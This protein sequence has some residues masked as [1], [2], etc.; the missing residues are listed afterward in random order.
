M[1]KEHDVL[2]QAV[3]QAGQEVLK[4]SRE[5]FQIY[6]KAD[7]SPVTSADLAANDILHHALTTAFPDDAWLSEESPDTPG[8]LSQP[9]VW[10][11]DPIDGT[12]YFIKGLPQYSI[13]VALADHAQP[14]LGVIY[15]PATDELFSAIHGHGARLN[16][17]PIPATDRSSGRLSLLVN[18]TRLGSNELQ[19]FTGNAHLHPMGS[20]AY[21]LALVAAG[22]ADG[23]V[24]FDPLHE[25]D[26][27][28]G[29]LLVNEAGGTTTDSHGN[30][31]VYNQ[32]NPLVRGI[33]AARHG[34][35]QP[36]ETLIAQCTTSPFPPVDG[37][38]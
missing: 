13:S 25:W 37:E 12:K 10:I 2:C 31:I 19:P 22:H 6:R 5:G 35:R 1:T 4:Q 24:N 21:S 9:R 20:I 30:V 34:M 14:V 26:V 17:K 3:R 27:V 36:F 18:P 8:R 7:S 16:G 38:G 33:F 29:W 23:T 15:N 11:V 28:A 32:T